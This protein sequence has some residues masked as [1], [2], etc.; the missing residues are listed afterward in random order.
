MMNSINHMMSIYSMQMLKFCCW[1]DEIT[2]NCLEVLLYT[3]VATLSKDI[4][5][6]PREASSKVSNNMGVDVP[7]VWNY[8]LAKLRMIC[9]A[10]HAQQLYRFHV[11]IHIFSKR[12]S[13][14]RVPMCPFKIFQGS[15]HGDQGA[16]QLAAMGPAG[17]LW[18][19]GIGFL[20]V[21]PRAE[22][23]AAIAR[24]PISK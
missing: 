21:D 5:R 18:K 19:A 22:V 15:C 3:W 14:W 16:R 11:C 7:C 8:L 9:I 12:D 20:E 17:C 2:K 23:L 24:I 1:D 10:L 4:Q 13:Q 6:A